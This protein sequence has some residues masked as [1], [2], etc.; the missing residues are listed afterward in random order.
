MKRNTT[1]RPPHTDR[2]AW[3]LVGPRPDLVL[4]HGF[5]DDADCWAPLLPDLAA[6]GGVLAV[7]ARGHGASALPPGPVGPAP[8]AADVAAVLDP[9]TTR[10]AVVV[11][12]SMGAVTA[13]HLAAARPDLVAALVLEDPPPDAYGD[14]SVRGVPEWLRA[15]RAVPPA[16]RAAVCGRD[17][18]RWPRD[19]LA[20]WAA[21]KDH[22]D[23]EFCRRPTA[24]APPLAETLAGLDCPVLL[25]HGAVRHGGMVGPSD[26][27]AMRRACDGRLTVVEFEDAGHNPRRDAR[28]DY[29]AALHA[30]IPVSA[31]SHGPSAPPP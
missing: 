19:E 8:Q 20:P 25:I 9:L 31:G 29:L 15:A 1:R 5:T 11:G 14:A 23:L 21:S 17:N 22:V 3:W 6:F 12:H 2:I 4:L 26:A 27:E 18:P 28:A 16:D 7:D 13:A 30:W 10:P 24:T